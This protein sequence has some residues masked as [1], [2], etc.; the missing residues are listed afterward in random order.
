MTSVCSPVLNGDEVVRRKGGIM[1]RGGL[2]AALFLIATSVHAAR[3]EATTSVSGRMVSAHYMNGQLPSIFPKGKPSR[4]CDVIARPVPGQTLWGTPV[5]A[6]AQWNVEQAKATG[7]DALAIWIHPRFEDRMRLEVERLFATMQKAGGLTFYPD[8]WC[9]RMDPQNWGSIT[10]SWKRDPDPGVEA[11]MRQQGKLLQSW[12]EKYGDVWAKK[13][14]RLIVAMQDHAL[15]ANVPYAKAMEWLFGPLGG[16]GKIYLALSR[17]PVSGTISADWLAGADA[18]IDWDANRTYGDS[19]REMPI[20][21]AFAQSNGKAWWPSFAPGFFV[22]RK[23]DST[24]PLTPTLYERLGIMA[25]RRAWLDAITEGSSNVYLIT[26][27]DGSEDS[28]VMPTASHGYAIQRLT[29]Y[30][31]DWFHQGK[32]PAI[33]QEQLLLFHHPQVV[34]GLQLPAGRLPTVGVSG[35]LTPPT[36]YVAV[37]SFLKEP[38]EVSVIFH[39]KTIDTQELPAGFHTWLLYHPAPASPDAETVVYPQAEEGLKITVLTA[40]FTDM[41]LSLKVTRKGIDLG[42]YFSHQ[43]IVEAAGRADMGTTGDVFTLTP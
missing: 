40:P 20:G 7:L 13:E 32:K 43:P 12:A 35:G 34:S 33:Q 6:S 18:I 15:F 11:E 36:D 19:R 5:V 22:S 29:R 3:A 21:K 37:C 42:R 2:L 41:E 28:E 14:G 25:Y 1:L 8:F 23:G 16:R 4:Q 27:N 17:Y 31:S 39:N 9:Y 10:P 38:A 30:F 26:W 24:A